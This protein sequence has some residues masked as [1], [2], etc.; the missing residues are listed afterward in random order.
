MTPQDL[1][2]S[3]AELQKAV[4]TLREELEETNQG[5]LFLT[6]EL[7]EAEAKYRRIFENALVGIYQ[8]DLAGHFTLV[9][10][11]L[12]KLLGFESP[13]SLLETVAGA[14]HQIYVDEER[15]AAFFQD[16][17]ET[18]PVNRYESRVIKR[19]GEIIWISENAHCLYDN[20]GRVIGFE[21]II[22]DITERK[23]FYQELEQKTRELTLA[24]QE[25]SQFAYVASHHL[26]E[27]LRGITSFSQLLQKRFE[28]HLGEEGKDIIWYIVKAA[29][30]MRAFIRDFLDYNKLLSRPVT[31]GPVE[32]SVA[33]K[34][35]RAPL[36]DEITETDAQIHTSNLA[37]MRVRGNLELLS[38]LFFHLFQNAIKFR[39]DSSPLVE[40]RAA[41]VG[42]TVQIEVSDNGI[43]I[44]PAYHDKVFTIFQKLYGAREY[45]GTGIGLAMCKR[46]IERHE[47][48]IWVE[49]QLGKGATFFFTLPAVEKKKD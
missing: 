32:V 27:P 37:N 19:D 21:G 10:H 12:A 40:V 20:D 9:N 41:P 17:R 6:R 30:D 45:P 46:I 34:R 39:G 42:D 28:S 23:Q 5:I 18:G 16:I 3:P 43:G 25:L 13:A 22:T 44:D 8:C 15:R 7:E 36:V 1:A 35:A 49:S 33:V 47:G 38:L 4:M 24:N 14:K 48:R 29:R 11:A 26:Q 31:L 2:K